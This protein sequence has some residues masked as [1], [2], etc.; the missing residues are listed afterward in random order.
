MYFFLT[1]LVIKNSDFGSGFTNNAGPGSARIRNTVRKSILLAT[2]IF[3]HSFYTD[4][5]IWFMPCVRFFPIK[6]FGVD[7]DP[8]IHAS[9]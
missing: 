7:P 8:R 2:V 6:H 9:D 5:E 3:R 4:N 1:F